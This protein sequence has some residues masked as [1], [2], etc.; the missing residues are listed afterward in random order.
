MRLV[1]F[2]ADM[3]R[4]NLLFSGSGPERDEL[5]RLLSNTGGTIFTNCISPA[6]DTPRSTGV[7]FTGKLPR[8]NGM[9]SRSQ[10]P[11]TTIDQASNTL[12]SDALKNNA[13]M[14]VIDQSIGHIQ[15]FF[16]KEI[17]AKS[18]FF[19]SLDEF[20]CSTTVRSENS[21]EIIFIVSMSYHGV[22]GVRH[23]HKSAHK[24]GTREIEAELRNTIEGLR[25][26]KGD[27]LVL[28][29]DHGCKLS[30]DT[31]GD[32]DL[33]DRDRAQVVF[34]STDFLDKSLSFDSRLLSM[35]DIHS[36]IKKFLADQ[37]TPK[38]GQSSSVKDFVRKGRSIVHVEDHETYDTKIGDPVRKWAV[39]TK[40]FEYFETLQLGH[41]LVLNPNSQISE[42]EA[43]SRSCK[44]LTE[45]AAD[46]TALKSQR[47]SLTSREYPEFLGK[48]RYLETSPQS[49]PV[50]VRLTKPIW[51]L[52]TL[53][54]SLL[55][56]IHSVLVHR[57]AVNK[58]KH[59]G[60]SRQRLL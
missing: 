15:L 39:Y 4:S 26:G 14:S 45:N 33:L 23:G 58:L 34:F 44:Y 28:F 50:S 55:R 22:V 7:F 49:K 40:N 47:D 13:K 38:A 57:F 37:L 43:M 59:G 53:K 29:S 52:L 16:P 51:R 21:T 8:E 17:V 27:H 35:R 36:S 60:G 10:W 3:L 46:Y 42:A 9:K 20:L 1:I 2:F 31:Y 5:E 11:G 25:L 41:K 6:P 54:T 48:H 18:K 19:S 56:R 32:F 24:A 12:F 30:N